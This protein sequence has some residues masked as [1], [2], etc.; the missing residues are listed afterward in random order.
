MNPKSRRTNPRG[1]QRGRHRQP[2]ASDTTRS[3]TSSRQRRRTTRLACAQQ[4]GKLVGLNARHLTLI[5]VHTEVALGWL[6]LGQL[7]LT[8]VIGGRT[9]LEDSAK[10]DIVAEDTVAGDIAAVGTAA[11]DTVTLGTVAESGV[12]RVVRAE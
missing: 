12:L 9:L 2:D 11:M 8:A 4:A 10:V 5:A 6:H 1:T 7:K 3:Q